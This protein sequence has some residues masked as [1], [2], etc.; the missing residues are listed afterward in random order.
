M[1]KVLEVYVSVQMF[2]FVKAT[3]QQEITKYI[4]SCS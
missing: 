3:L 2:V 4:P 1:V